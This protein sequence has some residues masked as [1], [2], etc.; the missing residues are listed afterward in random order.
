MAAIHREAEVEV[1]RIIDG[2]TLIGLPIGNT[3]ITLHDSEDVC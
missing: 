3:I 1:V 2:D